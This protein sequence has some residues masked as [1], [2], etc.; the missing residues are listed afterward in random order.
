M[1]DPFRYNARLREMLNPFSPKTNL[2]DEHEPGPFGPYHLI[3]LINTGG[4]ADLWQ[5]TNPEGQ[6]VAIRKLLPQLRRDGTAKKR[7][8]TGCEILAHIHEH[9]YIVHY[10]EHG[11]I[12]GIPFMAMEYLEGAN[13][14]EWIANPT[15]ELSQYI[16]NIVIDIGEALEHVHDCGY[17]HL[18]FKPENVLVSPNWNVRLIDFDLAQPRRRNPFKLAKSPGTPAYMSPEQLQRE[19]VD[20][21][22]DIFAYGVSIYEILTGQKPFSGASPAEILKKQL[23]RN[24]GFIPPRKL[25][26]DIPIGVEKTLLKSLEPDPIKRHGLLS[27]MLHDLRTALYM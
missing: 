18:D 7:F 17:M 13:L 4:M 24:I 14:K 8:N 2:P 16:G 27:V 11:K 1:P 19:P 26:P 9:D 23:N 20:H 22:A 5:A 6:T 25:N 15:E 3:E 21:R 12:K 10:F